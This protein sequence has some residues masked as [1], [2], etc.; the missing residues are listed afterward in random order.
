L[1]RFRILD[2]RTLLLEKEEGGDA[3][4]GALQLFFRVER[5]LDHHVR[6]ALSRW[7]AWNA[8]SHGIE[9][10]S[11]AERLLEGA[12]GATAMLT[13]IREIAGAGLVRIREWRERESRL[14]AAR[15]SE[16][17]PPEDG[18]IP[19]D[20]R[21]FQLKALEAAGP[22]HP[23]LGLY[24]LPGGSGK[25]R[26]GLELAK[27]AG[28]ALVLAPNAVLREQWRGEAKKW[29][30]FQKDGKLDKR[31]LLESSEVLRAAIPEKEKRPLIILDEAHGLSVDL[32]Q[33]L[34][35][36]ELP[37]VGLTA[38]PGWDPSRDELYFA[39]FGPCRF[40]LPAVMSA[41]AVRAT[42]IEIR[43]PMDPSLRSAYLLS[44]SVAM[45]H[46][47]AST[48]PFKETRVATLVKRHPGGRILI[49]GEFV[50][51]LER[52]AAMG[53]YP[54][55]TGKTTPAGR[56]KAYA[57]FNAAKAAVLVSSGVSDEG[58]D[59]PEA[60]VVIQ[61]SGGRGDAV[62]ELQ[63]LGRLLRPKDRAVAF[64]SLV[65]EN[66]IEEESARQRRGA[67][68]RL[69]IIYEIQ[70]DPMGSPDQPS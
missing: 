36:L 31:L 26:L 59:L 42:C 34:V 51:P 5:D 25:T 14:V 30:L 12:E 65:S 21:E 47:V 37:C 19:G 49:L 39:A 7:R 63:R 62:Q 55:V 20:L 45:R 60:D 54:V 15:N 6:L 61:I 66:T 32:L 16:G 70:G 58:I 68:E 44:R 23:R 43:V 50:E 67:V 29:G 1:S 2:S 46:Q 4:L 56:R 48:N 13:E 27:K 35:K 53:R 57:A 3:P 41:P 64:Y 24:V 69:G 52:V 33:I 28:G 38:T 18:P 22:G 40:P 10:M 9:V 11:E 17:P 8:L